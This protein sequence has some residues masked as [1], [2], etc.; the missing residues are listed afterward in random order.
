MSEQSG[1]ILYERLLCYMHIA[2]VDA[3]G[4]AAHGRDIWKLYTLMAAMGMIFVYN[5]TTVLFRTSGVY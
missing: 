4:I 3:W 2:S 1:A 5:H